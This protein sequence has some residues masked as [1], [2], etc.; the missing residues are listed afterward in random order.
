MLV[1]KH[2]DFLALD[3]LTGVDAIGTLVLPSGNPS[4]VD[5]IAASIISLRFFCHHTYLHVDISFFMLFMHLC[6]KEDLGHN[7]W[8]IPIVFIQSSRRDDFNMHL[9]TTHYCSNVSIDRIE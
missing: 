1:N 7:D 4:V 3:I 8:S 5:G 9:I 6:S 2:S